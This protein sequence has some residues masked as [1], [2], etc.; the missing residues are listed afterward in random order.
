MSTKDAMPNEIGVIGQ[1]YEDRKSKKRGV[2]ESRNEKYK[3]LMMRDE[4][5]GSFTIVYSTFRSNWRKYTGAEVI[6]TSAQVEEEKETVQ[7]A[8]KVLKKAKS[9]SEKKVKFTPDDKNNLVSAIV[10]VI[11]ARAKKDNLELAIKVTTKKGIM[12]RVNG[13]KLAEVW[14]TKPDYCAV[15]TNLELKANKDIKYTCKEDWLMRNVYEADSFEKLSDGLF[16]A[17]KHTTKEEK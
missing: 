17:L 13:K 8:N 12:L 1:I 15:C 4:K 3:T 6:K 16:E 10:D 5:G 7:V 14:P 11:E 2:L 9:V